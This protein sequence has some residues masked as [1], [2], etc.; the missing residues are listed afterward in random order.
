MEKKCQDF[1]RSK[2]LLWDCRNKAKYIFINGVGGKKY[3]CGIHKKMYPDNMV[4]KL[5]V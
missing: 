3:L 1:L 2:S 4:K 5:E